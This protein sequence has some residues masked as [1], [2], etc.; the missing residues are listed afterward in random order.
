M[1]TWKFPVSIKQSLG[2]Y[3]GLNCIR[4]RDQVVVLGSWLF[5]WR[6]N[7]FLGHTLYNKY[8]DMNSG[9]IQDLNV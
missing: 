6:G 3:S 5:I 1:Q 9:E 2:A 8:T 4:Q 7:V